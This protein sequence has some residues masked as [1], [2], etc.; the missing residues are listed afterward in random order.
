MSAKTV[1]VIGS[2]CFT[3]AHFVDALLGAGHR[4]V[5]VSRA[6]ESK[7]LYLPYKSRAGA[8]FEFRRLD[9]VTQMPAVLEFLSQRRPS[10]VVNVAALSE[11]ALSNE[12]PV[13]YYETNTLA[14]VR[15]TDFLRR[16]PWLER[17]AHVS[18]AEIFGSCSAPVDESALFNPSTPYA[19]SKAAADMHINTLIKNFGF[20]AALIRSTNVYG[21]HQ[22]LFKIVPRA[23]IR[24]KQGKLIELHGGGL[25]KKS[26]IHVRDVAAGLLRILE[27]GALG[28]F[29]FSVP[30]DRTVAGV[31]RVVA[32]AMGKDFDAVARTV[33][34]RLGQDAAYTLDCSRA[35][36]ELGWKP[37]V[38]FEDGV[39]ETVEWI[40]ANWTE[41]AAEPHEYRHRVSRAA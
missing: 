25:A 35:A 33:G 20:P 19:V 26:F 2:N 5:G 24:I 8:Q 37:A 13:E 31:V 1:V 38:R 36:R 27:K 10:V 4:V 12:S 3:G 6:P 40:E 18:S 7:P 32:E 17:Y 41:V 11:V 14:V 39:R 23:V 15:L 34:E 29:H 16:Q 28:T 22:Q 9:L 21:R 30:S